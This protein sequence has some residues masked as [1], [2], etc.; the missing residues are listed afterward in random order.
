V[1]IA[2]RRTASAELSDAHCNA[3]LEHLK[4]SP[5]RQTLA[6]IS[7]AIGTY[8]HEAADAVE[9]LRGL[10]MVD[11]SFRPFTAPTYAATAA[12]VL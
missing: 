11:S 3:V 7:D 5:K 1:P 10:R 12:A 9:R 8:T 2:T 4:R 6:E